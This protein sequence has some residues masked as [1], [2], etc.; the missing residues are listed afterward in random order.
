M[1]PLHACS[2]ITCCWTDFGL[3]QQDLGQHRTRGSH[4]RTGR[5]ASPHLQNVD[6]PQSTERS[7]VNITTVLSYCNYAPLCMPLQ[8]RETYTSLVTQTHI[9]LPVRMYVCLFSPCTCMT[10]TLASCLGTL[11]TE[12]ARHSLPTHCERLLGNTPLKARNG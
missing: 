11:C 6:P 8:P 9:P 7:G 1:S 4:W 12:T 3:R 10:Y 2:C 5:P